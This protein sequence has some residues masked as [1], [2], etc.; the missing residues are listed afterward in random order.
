MEKLE[1][2]GYPTVRKNSKISLFVFAQLTNVTD[3]QTNGHRITAYRA[4]AYASRGKNDVSKTS[5]VK[6]SD[7]YRLFTVI[8]L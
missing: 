6:K 3:R 7:S 2:R 5:I 8:G 4:Y 1:W